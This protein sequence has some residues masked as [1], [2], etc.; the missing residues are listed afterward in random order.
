MASVSLRGST[1]PQGFK[2]QQVY[3]QATT[4]VDWDKIGDKK[5][6]DNTEFID[7]LQKRTNAQSVN[8]PGYGVIVNGVDT[9]GQFKMILKDST[10]AD[11]PGTVRLYVTNSHKFGGVLMLED[12]TELMTSSD[13]PTATRLGEQMAG[14]Q[15]DS[16][17][18]ISFRADTS[19]KTIDLTKSAAIIPVTAY[20]V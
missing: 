1:S 14:A 16:Y 19:G 18:M 6:T 13:L 9:R 17:M 8:V 12:R 2:Y 5:V 7:I 10:G 3:R 11:I 20:V 15:E 4:L